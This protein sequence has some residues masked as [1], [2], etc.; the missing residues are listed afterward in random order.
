MSPVCVD[1]DSMTNV[2]TMKNIASQSQPG[3]N[4][5]VG[6]KPRPDAT[7]NSSGLIDRLKDVV[8]GLLLVLG[9]TR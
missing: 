4:Q 6:A 5:V 2:G 1:I 9:R 8:P 7:R 3:T